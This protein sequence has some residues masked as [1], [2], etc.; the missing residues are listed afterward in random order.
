M[1]NITIS[2]T[3]ELKKKMEEFPEINW[4]GL[5]RKLLIKKIHELAWKEEMSKQLKEEEEF[6]DWTVE[7][8]RKVNEGIAS[9]LK[10]EG[11]I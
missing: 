2:I 4:S 9:R 10:K 3:K 7:M 1:P 6:T 11:L 8:G 5:T